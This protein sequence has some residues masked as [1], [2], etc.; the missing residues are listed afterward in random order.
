MSVI[1]RKQKLTELA[2][3]NLI[4]FVDKDGNITIDAQNNG[5]LQEVT[6]TELSRGK[7]DPIYTRNTKVKLHNPIHAIAE[8]NK[9]EHIY[10]LAE[11]SDVSIYN[12]TLNIGIYNDFKNYTDE[13]LLAIISSNGG[14]GASKKEKSQE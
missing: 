7:D 2:R 4:D 14:R 11:P 9:M 12:Q 10:E 5:A 6:V 8:L 1:E 3:A 13:Q